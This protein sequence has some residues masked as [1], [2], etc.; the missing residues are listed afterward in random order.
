MKIEK[1]ESDKIKVTVFPED[2]EMFNLNIK[3][4][5]PDSPELRIFLCEIMKKVQVETNFDPF[6]GQVIVEA[7]PCGNELILMVSKLAEKKKFDRSRIKNVRAV[8]KMPE[9]YIYKFEN[10]DAVCSCIKNIYLQNYE[11]SELY[12][13][14]DSFYLAFDSD[15]SN[16]SIGEYAKLCRKGEVCYS[17][18]AEYGEL[19]ATGKKLLNIADF[20]RNE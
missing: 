15:K 4:I 11:I 19:I 9:K 8:K 7:T 3:K 10:F 2:L 12:S 6:D 13:M 1:V 18:L 17:Y 16:I 5:N 20:L 14:D